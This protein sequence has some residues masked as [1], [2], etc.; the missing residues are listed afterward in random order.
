MQ[1]PAERWPSWANMPSEL[2]TRVFWHLSTRGKLKAELVCRAWNGV[3]CNPQ[4]PGLWGNLT[5]QLDKLHSRIYPKEEADVD[6]RLR[7]IPSTPELFAPICRWTRARSPGME[8]LLLTT[9]H[10]EECSPAQPSCEQHDCNNSPD[11]VNSALVMLLACLSGRPLDIA[12]SLQCEA[13]LLPP[14]APAQP[15]D[16]QLHPTPRAKPAEFSRRGCGLL[17]SHWAP[18]KPYT[19]PA[20]VLQL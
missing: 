11:R 9:G 19:S 5:V 13:S 8:S 17:P 12:I 10:C 2:L 7:C 16:P 3:L 6:C 1:A 15:H 4:V 18:H 20:S 14:F